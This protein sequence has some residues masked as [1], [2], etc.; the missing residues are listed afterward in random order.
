MPFIE[1]GNADKVSEFVSIIEGIENSEYL[2]FRGANNYAFELE[3]SLFR[4]KYGLTD[5]EKV[6]N[7]E[8]K[9]LTI[10]KQRSI[11]YIES[12]FIERGNISDWNY[13]FLMQHFGIPTRLLDFSENSLTALYFAVSSAIFVGNTSDAVVYILDPKLWNQRVFSNGSGVA[14]VLNPSDADLDGYKPSANKIS[15]SPVAIFGDYNSRRIA[16]QQGTFLLFGS[17]KMSAEACMVEHAFPDICLRKIRIPNQSIAQIYKDLRKMG[18][19]ETAIYSDIV[20]LSTD[21]KSMLTS[22]G[23]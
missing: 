15:K 6:H 9:T 21:M 23:G 4:D 3:P 5:F 2:W 10:F 11:P 20:G 17:E 7:A 8:R 13:L 19:T 18:F 12:L 14:D 1:L 16:A 22:G